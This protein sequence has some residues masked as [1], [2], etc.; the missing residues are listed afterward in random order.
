MPQ[1]CP[2]RDPQARVM[3]GTQEITGPLAILL[4]LLPVPQPRSASQIQAAP[5]LSAC[6]ESTKP[7]S[8]RSVQ[9][10]QS[11]PGKAQEQDLRLA[12]L[13][14]P[15]LISANNRLSPGVNTKTME[16]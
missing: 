8:Y 5:L 11:N 14:P 2:Q 9:Q 7:S 1:Q 12:H 13:S 4:L 6:L 10:C 3:L 16:I 15:K